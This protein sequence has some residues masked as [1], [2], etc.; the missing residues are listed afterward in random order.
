M[1]SNTGDG[2]FCLTT[3]S[4]DLQVKQKEPSPVFGE[5]KCEKTREG[6]VFGGENLDVI[7]FFCNF[8]SEISN[9]HGKGLGQYHH[10]VA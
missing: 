6:D 8:A 4:A 2:S 9:H 1:E 10:A 7:D 5:A 3:I